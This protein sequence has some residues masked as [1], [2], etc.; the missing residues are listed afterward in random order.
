MSQYGKKPV[1]PTELTGFQYSAFD[2]VLK[3]CFIIKFP[4]DAFNRAA[5]CALECAFMPIANTIK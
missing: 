1:F 4:A 5:G 3:K 2:F